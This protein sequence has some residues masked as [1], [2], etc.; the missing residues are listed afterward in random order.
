MGVLEQI[1]CD[2]YIGGD[3]D[4]PFGRGAL[5]AVPSPGKKENSLSLSLSLSLSVQRG[6]A[7]GRHLLRKMNLSS[8]SFTLPLFLGPLVTSL[9]HRSRYNQPV[10]AA[11][12]GVLYTGALGGLGDAF[13]KIHAKEGVLA[14]WYAILARENL[15]VSRLDP[16]PDSLNR[17]TNSD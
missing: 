12:R 1:A 3:G 6:R 17:W 9:F 8:Q 10:D 2:S 16:A 11:G 15:F 14:F 7:V 4:E 5:P 13:T